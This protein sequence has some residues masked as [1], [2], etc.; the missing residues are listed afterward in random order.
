MVRAMLDGLSR[1]PGLELH[2]VNFRLSHDNADIGRWRPGKITGT[3]RLA[4]QAIREG[5]HYHSD[6]LYYVPSPPGKRGALYRDWLVML[7]CRP[8][9]RRLILHWHA[10]G[11][12]EWLEAHAVGVERAVT[13]V[14]LGR[15]ELAIVLTNSLRHDAEYLNAREI[16]VVPNGIPDPRPEPRTVAATIPYQTLFLGLGSAEKGLFAAADAVIAANRKVAAP[17]G[18]P[19]FTLVA[20]GPFADPAAEARFREYSESHPD[21]IRHVGFADEKTKRALFARSHCLIFPT[22]YAAEGLPLV[23]L[24]A[25]AHDRPI[26]ATRWRGLPDVVARNC[27][28]LVP[29]GEVTELT[30]ALI[31][32]RASP[33]APG[34]CRR[35]FE[36]EFTLAQH[37]RQLTAALRRSE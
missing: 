20:A 26:L 7:L 19:T 34:T 13:Q 36:E 35:R 16:A 18:Q 31:A 25:L 22:Q 33:P 28:I 27:G 37:L 14:L 12:A 3:L 5:R 29:P 1:E 6:T 30:D 2:H 9:F 11:L 17:A 23:V 4:I 8:F 15:A 21:A 10:V 24:E 32:L